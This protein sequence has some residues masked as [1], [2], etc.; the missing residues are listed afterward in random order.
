MEFQRSPVAVHVRRKELFMSW[1]ALLGGFILVSAVAAVAVVM[2]ST[3]GE[4][5]RE[6]AVETAAVGGGDAAPGS[7]AMRAYIDP[8]TGEIQAG[9]GPVVPL[10]L[11][12]GVQNALRRDSEG[13]VEVRHADGSVSIDLQGRFQSVSVAHIGEDGTVG[14][15]ACSEHANQVMRALEGANTP[16]VK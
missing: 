12:P 15:T 4:S 10:S 5:G 9:V 1:K 8:E 7:A 11:D 2:P 14:V 16:E 3:T 6:S 13:L